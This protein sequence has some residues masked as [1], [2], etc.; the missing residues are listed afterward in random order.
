[1]LSN[2][3]QTMPAMGYSTYQVECLKMAIDIVAKQNALQEGKSPETRLI[4]QFLSLNQSQKMQFVQKWLLQNPQFF[5]NANVPAGLK[6]VLTDKTTVPAERTEAPAKKAEATA[7]KTEAPAKKAEAP[8]EKAEAPAEKAE[9]PA[10]KTA[11]PAEKTEAPAEKT[12]APAEK[13]EAPA[14]KTA[15]A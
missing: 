13:T 10:E 5:M 8:A 2:L 3:T 1:M 6:K 7:E 11:A 14:E 9:A 15:A 4:E 12:E